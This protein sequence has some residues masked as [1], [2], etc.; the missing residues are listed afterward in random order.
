MKQKTE[1]PNH[2]ALYDLLIECCQQT[3][4]PIKLERLS[5]GIL[6]WDALL[7]SAYLHGIFPLLFKALKEVATMSE[8][9]TAR[10]KNINLQIARTNMMMTAELLNVIRL[11][12]ENG[13]RTIAIKGPVLS[14]I[15][16]RDITQRQFSDLDLLVHPKDMYRSLEL[17]EGIGYVS[18]HP[19]A[20]LKN[21]T[22]LKVGKDFPTTHTEK[23]VLIEF[24]WK[25]FLD[26]HIKKS[27]IDL[28]SD[29]NYHC[30][31]NNTSVETL[32]LDALL[33]YLLLHGSKHYWERLEWIVDIDR[34]IRIHSDEID[35]DAL[36]KMAQDM[37]I[38][39]MFYLG[40]AVSHELFHTPLSVTVIAHLDGNHTVVKA[41]EGILREIKS[42]TIK[43]EHTGLVSLENLNKILLM[44]D[45][46][47]G[48]V[49]QYLLV[50]FQIK[51]LDV[52]MVNL[53]NLLSPLYYLIRLYRLFKLNVLRLK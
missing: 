18:E 24:H 25:L 7:D 32:A 4:D 42:D 20:F 29:T 46:A 15:I 11:L 9:I 30:T 27:N 6:D 17:L 33:L 8:E 37:E 50:L 40:L 1:Q 52:Y 31:I 48:W 34:L 13:I 2:K 36:C 44:K 10:L 51:E 45:D 49:R 38:G 23:N 19:I 21:K 26:R 43:N 41:K 22:L 35:W 12:D 3:P 28:F 5:L 47:N 14:Q 39:F 53:P 16:H